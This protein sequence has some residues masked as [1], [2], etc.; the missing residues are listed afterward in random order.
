LKS[1]RLARKTALKADPLKVKEWK[2]LTA[3]RLPAQSKKRQRRSP[4]KVVKSRGL[5]GVAV[6]YQAGFEAARPLVRQRSKGVCEAQV[7]PDCTRTATHVHHRKMRSQGGSN[8]L[9]NL[10]DT[11][12]SCHSTIHGKPADSYRSGLLVRSWEPEDRP[13]VR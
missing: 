4:P 1:G 12:S 5:D 7:S 2:Q 3:R 10:L 13:L 8:A 11:C 6:T 9:V